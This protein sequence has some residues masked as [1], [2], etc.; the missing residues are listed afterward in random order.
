MKGS[1][2]RILFYSVALAFCA[3]SLSFS[4][5][6]GIYAKYISSSNE[7]TDSARVAKFDVSDSGG[8]I[9]HEYSL[10]LDPLETV[11]LDDSL[12]L[13]NSSEVDIKCSFEMQST[14][15]LPLVFTWSKDGVDLGSAKAGEPVSFIVDT[16]TENQLLD[17]RIDWDETD[18]SFIYRRQVDKL[19]LK[20]DCV[21][22]D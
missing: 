13:S 7:A 19:V 15:N 9:T 22:V 21:Q 6:S 18:K 16:N 20:I 5:L 12:N 14:A 17:L 1:K 11:S 4:V 2:K 10:T 8:M 3:L